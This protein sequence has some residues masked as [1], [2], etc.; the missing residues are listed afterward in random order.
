LLVN[1]TAITS[2]TTP[3]VVVGY[4][5]TAT[6]S[7]AFALPD[8]ASTNSA[9]VFLPVPTPRHGAAPSSRALDVADTGLIIG[10][11]GSL[12]AEWIPS[13][14]SWAYKDISELGSGSGWRFNDARAI[15]R[16]GDIVGAGVGNGS[17]QHAYLLLP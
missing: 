12:A 14:G 7:I 15:D 13:G 6:A 2:A 10:H 8:P 16:Q 3:A 4:G 17:T 5:D 11:V 1:P 9:P